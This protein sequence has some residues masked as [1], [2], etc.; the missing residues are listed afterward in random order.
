MIIYLFIYYNLINSQYFNNLFLI[1]S[2]MLNIFLSLLKQVSIEDLY[3]ASAADLNY[4]FSLCDKG[5]IVK[6]NGLNQKL[7]VSN[8]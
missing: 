4:Q 8:K 5:I 6:V 3:N 2:S 1:R 7:P